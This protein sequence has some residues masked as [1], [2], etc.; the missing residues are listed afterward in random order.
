MRRKLVVD[1]VDHLLQVRELLHATRER[2]LDGLLVEVHLAHARLVALRGRPEQLQRFAQRPRPLHRRAIAD[3]KDGAVAPL[4]AQVLVRRQTAAVLLRPRRKLV[5]DLLAQRVEL[6]PG[7]PHA[8]PRGDFLDGAGDGVLHHH[9]ILLHLLHLL[10]Q[11]ALDV[12][13]LEKV[14][15]VLG[16]AA[17]VRAQ[18]LLLQ[19]DDGDLD[20]R[21]QTTGVHLRHVLVH[22]VVQLRRELDARRPGAD[23]DER[24]QLLEPRL[25]DV[26]ERRALE[27]LVHLAAELRGVRDLL[28]EHGVLLDARDAERVGHRA[29][30]GDE[31]VVVHV[32]RVPRAVVGILRAL[33]RRVLSTAHDLL[34]HRVDV[35]AARLVVLVALLRDGPPDGLNDRALLHRARRRAGQ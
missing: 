35:D 13:S 28:K 16:D 34:P 33:E 29:H 30:R 24:E 5:H 17:I 6:D 18:D 19:V 7:A 25:G 11:E 10:V 20:V 23:D 1:V 22:H 27:P 3:G 26:G 31:V 32:E 8:E 2:R 14:G 12:G 15:G 4:D 9:A 21:E